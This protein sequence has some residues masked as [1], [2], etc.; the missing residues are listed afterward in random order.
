MSHLV[1]E[2]DAFFAFDIFPRELRGTT[3]EH[4]IITNE[5]SRINHVEDDGFY[6]RRL[7]FYCCP[8]LDFYSLGLGYLHVYRKFESVEMHTLRLICKYVHCV[9]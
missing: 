5:I 3:R 7:D 1:R 8:I 4:R 6:S 9:L 2:I